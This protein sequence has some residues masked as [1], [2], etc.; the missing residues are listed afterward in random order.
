MIQLYNATD[1]KYTSGV[2]ISRYCQKAYVT[3]ILN[4]SF[5]L[6]LELIYNTMLWNTISREMQIRV[7][8]HRG[9]LTFRI[10]DMTKDLNLLKI[11]ARHL[12]WDLSNNLIEDIYCAAMDG[13]TAIKKIVSSGNYQTKWTASSD[14]II[15]K[16]CRIVQEYMLDALM[17]DLDN[18]FRNRW[19]GELTAYDYSFTINMR[20]GNKEPREIKFRKDIAG[21]EYFEDISELATRIMPIGFDGLTLPE[22]YIDSPLIDKYAQIYIKKV[23]LESIKIKQ[24]EE[25]EGYTSKEEAYKA[26]REAVA[27]MYE[28]QEVDKPKQNFRANMILLRQSEQYAKYNIQALEDIQLGDAIEVNLGEYN[29]TSS[30]R[31]ISITY[32]CLVEKY[33]EVE[34]GDFK[35]YEELGRDYQTAEI[36]IDDKLEELKTGMYFLFNESNMTINNTAEFLLGSTT[37]ASVSS[38]HLNLSITITGSV[39]ALAQASMRI[40]LNNN[41]LDMKPK[42]TIQSGYFTWT[43]SCPLLFIKPN[44]PNMLNIYVTTDQPISVPKGCFSATI[45]GQAISGA[46][47]EFP[48]IDVVEEITIEDF[49][50]A[51]D[52][53]IK[54]ISSMIGSTSELVDISFILPDIYYLEERVDIESIAYGVSLVPNQFST[55]E[56]V[57]LS[58]AYTSFAA[59]WT[60]AEFL[61]LTYDP[62]AYYVSSSGIQ[63][64]Q[65][66]YQVKSQFVRD[67]ESTSDSTE[68]A[69]FEAPLP[70]YRDYKIIERKEE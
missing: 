67:I 2:N 60:T 31:C 34:L 5:I 52:N 11:R 3:E 21:F 25:D 38:T 19:G 44:I 63:V 43:I 64:N 49:Q 58:V 47:S 1:T 57:E 30:K 70:S 61:K 37:F 12:L 14:I 50:A 59:Y 65:Q 69:L 36:N 62:D 32:D 22:K 33:I 51:M 6:E 4:G 40:V 26:M 10:L 17:G 15:P 48:A 27:F 54:P 46:S 53:V 66:L 29:I 9:I 20:R 13:D 45:F 35:G 41:D 39:P 16:N 18:S 68:V 28:T 42:Q 23:K 56:V 8:T 7:P 55:H 24:N